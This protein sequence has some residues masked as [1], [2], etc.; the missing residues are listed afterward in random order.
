MIAH[1]AG[2]YSSRPPTYHLRTHSFT[3]SPCRL[4]LAFS[5]FLH[6]AFSIS[7]PPPLPDFHA[8]LLPP[9]DTSTVTSSHGKDSGNLLNASGSGTSGP[10]PSGGNSDVFPLALFYFIS[11]LSVFSFIFKYLQCTSSGFRKLASR[12]KRSLVYTQVLYFGEYTPKRPQFA[13]C[14]IPACTPTF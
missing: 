1:T 9:R 5:I 3:K 14:E 7:H 12:Q 10:Q 6:P 11:C 8:P 13:V 4:H 2:P